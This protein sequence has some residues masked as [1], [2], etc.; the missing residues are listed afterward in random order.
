MG[1]G[2]DE[3]ERRN[4]QQPRL[5][6]LEF[7]QNPGMVHLERKRLDKLSPAPAGFAALLRHR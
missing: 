1:R 5:E 6:W 4:R 7:S 2:G 3:E